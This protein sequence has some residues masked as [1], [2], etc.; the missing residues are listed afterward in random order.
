[1]TGQEMD[2]PRATIAFEKISGTVLVSA[3]L[4]GVRCRYDAGSRPQRELLG[5]AGTGGVRL[6]P[7]CPEQFGGLPTPRPRS[8]LVGGDGVAVIEGRACVADDNGRDVTRNFLDGAEQ[9]Y[10]LARTFHAR[11]AILKDRSPSCAVCEVWVDGA[12]VR[13]L[14]VTSAVLRRMGVV[15]AN[16]LGVSP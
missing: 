9:V 7:V 16:E 10:H 14:G 4:L 5:M 6:V 11:H 15:L 2:I 13:G 1:M 8:H 12:L 3:C